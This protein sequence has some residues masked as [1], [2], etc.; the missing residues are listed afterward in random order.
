MTGREMKRD[1]VRDFQRMKGRIKQQWARLSEDEIEQI[2]G[3]VQILA[4]KLQEHYGWDK[5]EAER[6]AR[7]FSTR[8]GWQ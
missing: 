1:S 7:D 8:H 5:E 6:Q 3:D 2:E 4:S